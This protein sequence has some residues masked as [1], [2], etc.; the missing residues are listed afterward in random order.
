MGIGLYVLAV[1]L[2]RR[3][4]AQIQQMHLALPVEV[5]GVDGDLV[6]I[7][8]P[9]RVEIAAPLVVGGLGPI[10]LGELD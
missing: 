5:H 2:F 10:N 1:L 6:P 8:A 4:L 7:A 9:A 3:E